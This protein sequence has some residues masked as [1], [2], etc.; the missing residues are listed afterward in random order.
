VPEGTFPLISKQGETIGSY[1]VRLIGNEL[2]VEVTLKKFVYYRSEVSGGAD[3]TMKLSGGGSGDSDPELKNI[4][5]QITLTVNYSGGGPAV[6]PDESDYTLR[7]E[8]AGRSEDDPNIDYTITA[9]VKPDAETGTLLNGRIL[10]DSIPEGLEITGVQVQYNGAGPAA[11]LDP[12]DYTD[13]E[14]PG[15]L[16][17]TFPAYVE[18]DETSA[19]T[20]A[21]FLV[22]TQLTLAQYEAFMAEKYG[23][24][25]SFSNT[26][27]LYESE[28]GP[29]LAKSDKVTSKFE[30]TFMTK[31]NVPVGI[32]GGVYRWIINAHT[33]FTSDGHVYLVDTIRNTDKTH[34]YDF[35][36]DGTVEFTVKTADDVE[37]ETRYAQPD[38]GDP[39]FAV[40][41]ESLTAA[42]LN[43]LMI[44]NGLLD[45]ET[46][47]PVN[48]EAKGVYYTYGTNAVLV[49]PLYDDDEAAGR[50]DLNQPLTVTYRTKVADIPLAPDG[51]NAGEVFKPRELANKVTMLWDEI[52][53]DG[54]GDGG[55]GEGEPVGE[56]GGGGLSFE[57]SKKAQPGYTLLKKEAGV[58]DPVKREMT[59]NFTIN[60][61]G[62]DMTG[63]IVTDEL[64]DAVQLFKKLT[65]SV[66]GGS[67]PAANTE[68]MEYTGSD[69]LASAPCY[70]KETVDHETTL[71]IYLGD[72]DAG[73]LYHLTL[74]TTVVDPRILS[75]D[76]REELENSASIHAFI[77]GTEVNL[78]SKGRSNLP[79]TLLTK[80]AVGSYDFTDHTLKWKVTVNGSHVPLQSGALLTDTL[81][82][83]VTFAAL[84]KVTRVF[85]DE[86]IDDEIEENIGLESYPANI[87]FGDGLNIKLEYDPDTNLAKAYSQ[88][89]VTFTF[90]TGGVATKFTDSFILEFTTTVDQDYRDDKF[91]D[92]NADTFLN[93]SKL[94]AYV[95]N[96]TDG[97][98]HTHFTAT[99][100]ATHTVDAPPVEKY[101]QYH[102][103]HYNKH[104][105]DLID[106]P[107]ISWT[108]VLNKDAVDM[109][110]VEV[111]DELKSFFELIPESLEIKEAAVD[112]D[113]KATPKADAVN[114]YSS[115]TNPHK[116]TGGFS[117]TIPED[118]ATTPLIITF[119]TLLIGSASPSQMTNMVTLTWYGGAGTDTGNQQ[120]DNTVNFDADNYITGSKVPLLQVYKTSANNAGLNP[121]GTPKFKLSGAKFTLTPMK[122]EGDDWVPDASQAAKEKV[123]SGNGLASFLFL[124]KN[125]LY[126]L[127]ETEA[128]AGYDRDTKAYFYIF[129]DSA[130]VPALAYPDDTEIILPGSD[131]ASS[132]KEII[133]NTPTNP[134]PADGGFTFSFTKVTD[135]GNPLAG[136]SFTLVDNSGRL[137]PK[138]VSSGI[139]G[140][141]RFSN[142]DPGT[143]TLT[144]DATPPG[145]QPSGSIAVTVTLSGGVYTVGMSGAADHVSGNAAEGFVVTNDYIRGTVSLNKTDFAE[146][147][148]AV[149]GAEFSVYWADN[150]ALAAYLTDSDGDGTYTLS[151]TNAAGND[152]LVSPALNDK[153]D[154]LLS[155]Q[156]GGLALLAGEYYVVETATPAGYLPD[157]DEENG[158][159]IRHPF[160]IA[161]HGQHWVVSN[162]PDDK[163]TNDPCGVIRGLKKTDSGR[164]LANAV[165]G[166]FPEGTTVFIQ[167]NLFDDQTAISDSGGA[168]TFTDIP[169]DTYVIAELSAPSGYLRNRTTSYVVTVNQNTEV[170]TKADDDADLVIVNTRKKDDEDPTGD[171]LIRKTSG[172]GVLKGF[173]FVITGKSD[174][175][176]EYTTNAKGQIR[177]NNLEPGTYTVYE[178]ASGLTIG[179]YVLP[180]AQTV[181]LT[182]SGATLD[183]HNDLVNPG[184]GPIPPGPTPPLPAP[185]VPVDPGATPG[186]PGSAANAQG[187]GS[188]AA[189]G[190]TQ[191]SETYG[192]QTGFTTMHFVWPFVFVIALMGLT[193]CLVALRKGRK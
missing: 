174:F 10:K 18:G 170:I 93:G 157:L 67:G 147:E 144:E 82:E 128:P 21:E 77:D 119:D 142:V 61:A 130:D 126:R 168:F 35:E 17:F 84:T 155:L 163:F 123:T 57:I 4:E 11:P 105:Y 109:N 44:K 152:T 69:P 172:D 25:W 39:A 99:A 54:D 59:W 160:T 158:T 56:E 79:N 107:Y 48:P 49:I 191:G 138:T 159:A 32:N 97:P 5:G 186:S 8:A 154:P 101:G 182:T 72:I 52:S 115:M 188:G 16:L 95:T 139:D 96:P 91:A 180:A 64:D 23:D 33:Y 80:E 113:G 166:L 90:T 6:D 161:T 43:E 192:P 42:Y 190:H 46:L 146:P 148:R 121:D 165:I 149:P 76:Q 167:A 176:E 98:E 114:L 179:R 19:I 66:T 40:P 3:L 53:Y 112:A 85:Y 2:Q 65:Y 51:S 183:F 178:K 171:I 137:Q 86:E 193:V 129:K 110:G 108:I 124:K 41:Y 181:R 141:V 73:E 75:Q 156:D 71:T 30:G 120:A 145:F 122:P 173:T 133:A 177:I 150:D 175:H 81:P 28:E 111:K 189:A 27:Y 184:P 187:G 140:V 103:G 45:S 125:V 118:Y 14:D 116:D 37:A 143:Y 92:R 106:A 104:G 78:G 83:G 162:A 31:D 153:Y 117:F 185:P 7:K 20:S 89:E 60:Q 74:K 88:G 87:T 34:T 24:E 50:H 68:I 29:P 132:Y 135:G 127:T 164:P 136:V 62:Q 38:S 26:A 9:A 13:P 169:Y 55:S 22:K 58:Y 47:L 102:R 100:S 70:T 134:N 1:E 131:G 151:N 94:D 15:A 63:V 36:T 12:A